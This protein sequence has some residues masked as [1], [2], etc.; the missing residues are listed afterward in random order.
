ML[1]DYRVKLNEVLRIVSLGGPQHI[2]LLHKK[3]TQDNDDD[4]F[5]GNLPVSNTIT[6]W[7][8]YF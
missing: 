2:N 7:V 1:K 8:S 5:N 4:E 6:R 3:M